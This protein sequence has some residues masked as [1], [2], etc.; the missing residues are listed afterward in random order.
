MMLARL[1]AT[2]VLVSPL[3]FGIPGTS[4]AAESY[5]N[6]TG[7]IFLPPGGDHHA[8]NLVPEEGLG[9]VDDQR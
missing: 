3:L 9:H 7:F 6:C 5:D 8:G 2:A 4:K 1:C